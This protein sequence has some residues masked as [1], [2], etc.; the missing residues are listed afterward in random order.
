MDEKMI[1]HYMKSLGLTREEAIQLIKDDED[2]VSVELTPEQKA[3]VKKMTQGERKKETKK[4]N[5]ERKVD[6]TKKRLID[7]FNLAIENAGGRVEGVKSET[8]VEFWFEGA[9]YSLRLVKH[10]E[11]R[12]E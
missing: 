10:R 6:E 3:V 1:A 11:K 7:A 5:R 4:R 9:G 8:E 12:G 2:D